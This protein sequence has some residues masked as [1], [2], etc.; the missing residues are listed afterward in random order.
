[1]SQSHLAG[2]KS[3]FSPV[4]ATILAVEA[5]ERFAF[6]GFRAILVLYFT[7]ALH[8]G[9]NQAIAL[10]AYTTC[11]AYMSPVA[12]AMVAD[13]K[14]GRYATIYY[15]GFVY[16][17]GLAILTAA[18]SFV[19]SLPA[20]RVLSFV[21]LFFVCVGTGGI[22]PCV[23]SF[24]ADQ[25]LAET[26]TTT[27]M[28]QEVCVEQDNGLGDGIAVID[29]RDGRLPQQQERVR[30]F[31]NYF[32]LCINI[33][34]LASI[35]V[36]PAIKGYF[37][38]GA[39]FFSTLCF[40]VTAMVLFVSRRDDY[41]HYKPGEDGSKLSET[42]ILCGWLIRQHIA[43]VPRIKRALP[44]LTPGPLPI[45]KHYQ[46]INIHDVDDEGGSDLLESEQTLAQVTASRAQKQQLEDAAQV[47]K[48][49]PIMAMFPIFW[50]LYDQQGS[51]WTLQA[52]RM[53]LMNL[54]PE[55]MTIINPLE[56]M[57]FIPLFDKI[58]YPAMEHRGWNIAPLRRISWGMGLAALSFFIS[59]LTERAI[60][61]RLDNNLP[62]LNVMWQ[63]PQLTILSIAEI[64]L[65]VTSQEFA[66]ATSPDSLKA[67]VTSIYLLTTAVGDLIGGLLYS[68]I[69][70]GVSQSL[71]MQICSVLML[72]NLALFHV[73]KRRWER[74]E[75]VGLSHSISLEGLE[76]ER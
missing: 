36:V 7:S 2:S 28:D 52:G 70:D 10:F 24:G 3:W 17:L 62:K 16:V 63:L 21:G 46:T 57:I 55:Q 4:T 51:V 12:G 40:M 8:Y 43:S 68:T 65:S 56:I 47:V 18:A 48:V 30:A 35:A 50:C 38:Y 45:D 32:Y 71:V 15:F 39:A 41:F 11:L 9:N 13:G 33:G 73:V 74:N 60:H 59:G 26:T 69:F 64:F 20:K 75:L 76:L 44:F 53:D 66:Y 6:F 23:S 49:L 67:F 42:F 27:N 72:C 1:M 34:A 31:F 19:E 29:P 5:A 58:I 14:I 22:K 54:Q 25:V 37:G 61:Y